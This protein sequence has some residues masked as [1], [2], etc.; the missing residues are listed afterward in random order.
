MEYT[1]WI[2]QNQYYEPCEDVTSKS[3]P[4]Q[5][6]VYLIENLENGMCY[7]GKKGF[8]FSKTYQKNKKKRRCKVESDWRAYFGSSELLH[9][10]LE[11]Y[12]HEAFRRTILHLCR[13]KG[14]ASY[15]E[16]KEQFIRDVLLRD[17]Y[18]NTWTSVRV[19]DS[20]LKYLR[21]SYQP[22]KV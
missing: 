22:T 14:E 21:E 18:Y 8:T 5:G 2:Y 13:S 9:K 15:L 17:D 10:D 19:R 11:L 7:I 16:A 1:P 3:F 20:H 4:Y 12:G 6:F